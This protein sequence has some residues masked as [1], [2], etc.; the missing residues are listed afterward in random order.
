MD[1]KK[2]LSALAAAGILTTGVI[3]ANVNATTEEEY[4]KPVGVY[5]K[6][7][8]GKNVVPYVL[9]DKNT[10]LTVKDIKAEFANLTSVKG[11]TEINDADTLGTGDTFVA[12]EVEYTV[13]VYGDVT[14]DGKI[15]TAD[16]VAI[17]KYFVGKD[18]TLNAVQLEAG[19][20]ANTEDSTVNDISTADALAIQK[21]FVGLRDSI[22]DNLP[23]AED[24]EGPVI[25]GV[26][27][28]D[29]I[30]VKQGA[31]YALPEVTAEDAVDGEVEVKMSI[32]DNKEFST[33]N[34]DTFTITY[35]AQDS[36][37]HV[38]TATITVI[39]DGTAPRADVKYSTT[40]PTKD[41]VTVTIQAGELLNENAIPEG[42]TLSEDK[43]SISK[44]YTVIV[45]NEEITIQDAAGNEA[46][47]YVTISNIDSEVDNVQISYS[48]EQT[49]PTNSDVKVTISA[50]EEIQLVEGWAYVENSDNKSIE[51]TYSER[52]KAL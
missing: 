15:S 44:V 30:Y 45:N 36:L 52:Y 19:D 18:R 35:S 6:L 31:E 46:K 47:A 37:E 24:V 42:W 16:A 38:T 34:E 5:Q 28:G 40:Q 25:S 51:K 1:T 43:T 10:L 9:K 27:N 22:I 11:S 17:Q 48:V 49:Q 50:D 20:V 14:G 13:V 33:E 3:G 2:I 7:V 8:E 32:A 41:G 39:V 23:P 21:Y 12:G 26:T 29:T 4:L